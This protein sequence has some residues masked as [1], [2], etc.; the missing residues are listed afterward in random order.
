MTQDF[1]VRAGET[2]FAV[3]EGNVDMSRGLVRRFWAFSDARDLTDWLRERLTSP[4]IG[5]ENPSKE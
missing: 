2:G 5:E 1:E 4:A 3:F